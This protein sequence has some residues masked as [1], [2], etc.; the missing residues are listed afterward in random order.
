[1]SVPKAKES[2][3]GTEDTDRIEVVKAASAH[4]GAAISGPNSIN[5]NSITI[6]N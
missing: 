1:M 3:N 4:I 6:I 5:D 2:N